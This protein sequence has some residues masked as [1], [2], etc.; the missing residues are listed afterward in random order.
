MELTV[1]PAELSPPPRDPAAALD[2]IIHDID[3]WLGLLFLCNQLPV[4]AFDQF[5]G[6]S[7]E[8][9]AGGLSDQFGTRHADHH[10]GGLVDKDVT[11]IARVLGDDA[12]RYVFDERRQELLG[13]LQNPLALMLLGNV[14][15]YRHPPAAIN[16]ALLDAD[17]APVA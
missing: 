15:M 11:Q 17:H 12:F 7:G 8:Q 9:F 10:L 4:A 3:D 1:G 13:P 16:R 6:L 14:L 5:G 2:R